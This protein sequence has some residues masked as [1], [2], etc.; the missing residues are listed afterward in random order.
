[1]KNCLYIHGAFSAF[2]PDSPKVLALKERF[3]VYGVSYSMED[4][5]L[6]IRNMLVEKCKLYNIDFVVGTSLGGLFAAEINK[7]LNTP[8]VLLNPCIEAKKTLSDF[9]KD[10]P[11]CM[12]FTTGKP[13]HLSVSDANLYPEMAYL[14]SSCLVFLGLKDQLIDANKSKE[15]AKDKVFDVITNENEDH[16]WDSF[17]ENDK[18]ENFLNIYNK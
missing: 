3:N 6:S 8:A 13:E 4:S 17:N 15:I 7:V 2:K 14:S 5:F 16:F 18:I 9:A 12:N 11:E 1:M 10:N